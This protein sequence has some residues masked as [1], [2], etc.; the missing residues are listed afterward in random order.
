[1]GEELQRLLV[2]TIAEMRELKGELREFKKHVMG[3]VEKLEKKE[4][5]RRGD[6]KATVSVLIA[7][8]AL[9]VSII[10]NFF[11]HGGK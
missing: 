9:A 1:M 6:L 7:A 4:G 2:D 10:V 11:R 5:E 3:R 8:A